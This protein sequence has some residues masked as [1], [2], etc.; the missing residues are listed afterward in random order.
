MGDQG[1][2]ITQL[3]QLTH[4]SWD[5]MVLAFGQDRLSPYL[6][7]VGGNQDQ[8]I[9]LYLWNVALCES[10][11]PLLNLSE[12]TLRNRFH[13]E[14]SIKYKRADWYECGW[15]DS[16]EQSNVSAAKQKL[17]AHRKLLTEGNIVAELTFGFWTSLLDVRYERSKELWPSL[18]PIV[19]RSAPRRL[20]T[21]KDQSR[22]AAQLRILRNRVFH[23]EPIWHWPNL[24]DIVRESEMWLMWLSPDVA[25][26]HG[27]LDRFHNVYTAG[28]ANIPAIKI[29]ESA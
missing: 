1:R 11:Y 25:R 12:V 4:I 15:L 3:S 21:R 24:P 2:S 8:A 13:H 29:T 20:R 27:L 17:Q 18:A 16:R 10:L 14:L 7:H 6:N 9:Q 5:A 23:H 26:L 22:Y 28:V 19:F